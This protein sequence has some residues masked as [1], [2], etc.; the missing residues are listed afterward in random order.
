LTKRSVHCETSGGSPSTGDAQAASQFIQGLGHAN[1]CC[2]NNQGGSWC[3]TMYCTGSA[4]VGICNNTPGVN[5][6]GCDF[7]DDV[8]NGLLDLSNSCSS[9][10]RSG[11]QVD[12]PFDLHAI[13]FHS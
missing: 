3:T 2:Q 4:C 1:S 11:G 13:L 6:P 8:G 12:L 9:G 7:C 5:F 10:G